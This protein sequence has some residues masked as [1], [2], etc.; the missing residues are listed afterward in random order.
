MNAFSAIAV[1]ALVSLVSAK[2]VEQ[3]LDSNPPYASFGLFPTR[4]DDPRAVKKADWVFLGKFSF[5]KRDGTDYPMMH[6]PKLVLDDAAAYSPNSVVVVYD[7]EDTSWSHVYKSDSLSCQ[8]KV[9]QSKEFHVDGSVTHGIPVAQRTLYEHMRVN[10]SHPHYWYIVV[11]NCEEGLGSIDYELH[12]ENPGGPWDKEFGY[13]EQGLVWIYV[14]FMCVFAV[15]LIVAG[16]GLYRMFTE[17]HPVGDLMPFRPL[18][19]LYILGVV[20]ELVAYSLYIFHYSIYA[21]D[22]I[23]AD[24]LK[25]TAEVLH[26]LSE[27]T[28][29]LLIVLIAKGWNVREYTTGA[30]VA[31]VVCMGGLFCLYI[32][33]IVEAN[34]HAAMPTAIYIYDTPPGIVLNCLRVAFAFLLVAI[35]V[36]GVVK[37]DSTGVNTDVVR[38]AMGKLMIFIFL[39]V[40][41]LV[42]VP[43]CSLGVAFIDD[44]DREKIAVS[45]ECIGHMYGCV[46]M[47]YILWPSRIQDYFAV[48]ESAL[49]ESITAEWN[50]GSGDA[51]AL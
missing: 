6:V 51:S 31:M 32:A 42:I 48:K 21:N 44:F 30:K 20:L 9:D 37:A 39:V 11:A 34:L 14:V 4:G 43:L 16:I 1:C 41:W 45:F 47:L 18:M 36:Y 13:D 5:A 8:E 2:V 28:L 49:T 38:E 25:I 33:M 46:M 12:F 27:C 26:G 3:T 19:Q 17:F 29:I 15:I 10:E 40:L 24:G 7:D 22:G 35:F 23:G 50:T